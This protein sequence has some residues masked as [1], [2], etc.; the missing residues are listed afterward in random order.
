MN[1]IKRVPAEEFAEHAAEYLDGPDAVSV[2]KDGQIIGHYV[3]V[4]NERSSNGTATARKRRKDSPEAHE[5]YERLKQLVQKI[6]A[7]NGMTEDDFADL[8]DPTK[9]FPC[10]LDPTS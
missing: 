1:E 6:R 5:N 3:P 10:N 7:R 8:F 4:P 2:E 9:S